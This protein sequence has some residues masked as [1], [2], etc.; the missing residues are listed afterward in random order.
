MNVKLG[1]SLTHTLKASSKGGGLHKPYKESTHLISY[2]C[3]TFVILEHP[4]SCPVLSIWCA[5]NFD[6]GGLNIG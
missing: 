4:T 2:R 1:L 6:F 3:G 5:D